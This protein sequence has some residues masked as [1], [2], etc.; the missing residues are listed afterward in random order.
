MRNIAK[1][2]YQ[3]GDLLLKIR[4]DEYWYDHLIVLNVDFYI[5]EYVYQLFTS[6]G[7]IERRTAE[8]VQRNYKRSEDETAEDYTEVDQEAV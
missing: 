8:W 3:V 1:P 7:E 6:E 5:D 4:K 2:T